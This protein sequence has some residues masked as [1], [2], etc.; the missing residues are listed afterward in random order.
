MSFH[1]NIHQLIRRLRKLLG[2]V[3]SECNRCAADRE[4][5]RTKLESRTTPVYVDDWQTPIN[6][7]MTIQQAAR[8]TVRPVYGINR[9]FY[10]YSISASTT[11]P[12]MTQFPLAEGT[13][14]SGDQDGE[15]RK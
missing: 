1:T 4:R 12:K 5:E 6:Q 3:N 9:E 7:I 8:R 11:L 2:H 14:L 13:N 15:I 10:S